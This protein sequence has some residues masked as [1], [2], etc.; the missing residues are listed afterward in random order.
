M[1]FFG[2]SAAPQRRASNQPS[3]EFLRRHECAACPLNREPGLRHPKMAATGATR[4]KAY[5]LAEAPGEVEDRRGKQMVGPAGSILRHHLPA[6]WLDWIR[7]N[8]SIRCRPPDNRDPAKA[9]LACCAP[10]VE[11]DLEASGARAVVG[12]GNVALGWAGVAESGITLWSGRRAPVMIAGRPYWYFPIIHPSAVQRDK[13]WD[14]LQSR[15]NKYGSEM[16]FQFALHLRR[17]LAAIAAGLPEPEVHDVARAK[18]G[19]RWVTG[20]GGDADVERVTEHLRRAATR[21]AAGF[22]YETTGLRPYA[23]GMKILTAGVSTAKDGTLSFAVDHR[24]ARWN[25]RQRRA[26]DEEWRRF[27][28]EAKCRKIAHNA[29]FEM[30]WSGYFYGTEC[31]RAGKWGDSLAQAYVADPTPGTH[32][33]EFLVLQHFGINIKKEFGASLDMGN[34]DREPLEKVLRYQGP[35]AKYCR[36]LHAAQLSELNRDGMRDLYFEH[37]ERIPTAVL[38]QLKGVPV[39]QATVLRLGKKY[40]PRMLDAERNLHSLTPVKKFERRA[41]KPF[42]PSANEDVGKVLHAIGVHDFQSVDEPEL[43][44]IDHV[45][46]REMLKWRKASK[47]YGTYVMPTSDERTRR[48]LEGQRVGG[49]REMLGQTADVKEISSSLIWPDG[50]GHPQTNVNRTRTSRT[51]SHEWN[52][53]NWPKRGAA[54]AI[55]VRGIVEPVEDDEVV[56]SF[57]FGQI[58]ARNVGMESLD[59]ALLESFWE[60]YD[61]HHDFMEQLA[62]LY[63]RWVKEGAKQLARDKALVKVYRNN[64]KHGFVFASFF[65]SGAKK[66]AAVLGIP[67]R[68]SEQ[69]REIFWDRFGGIRDWHGKLQT[70]YYKHGYVTGHSGYRRHAPVSYNELINSPIQADESKIVLDA[71][72][73]LSKIDHDLL[74]ATMEIHDDLTFIWPKKRVDELADIVLREM[75]WTP[76]EWARIAP[77]VVEMSV[78]KN[79]AT[80]KEPAEGGFV[81]YGKGIF[82]SNKYQGVDMPRKMGAL[83]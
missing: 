71:M 10:S 70:D 56:V 54:D 26:L 28:Y 39:N 58:Q 83:K 67:L 50:M 5:F 44:K 20:A 64:V 77:I 2:L 30:E 33:L 73:R 72:T 24:E 32:S 52:Y 6:R 81:Q 66:N 4:A 41:G 27:L 16:E 13:K 19:C 25:K 14:G 65:G 8:N 48:K 11:R 37:L 61:I 79:W 12:F 76:F 35:D 29:A 23:E 74:Q 42:R 31:V 75:L 80:L 46:A 59:R 40:I 21:K 57:D 55:E 68:V 15:P 3:L 18:E 51:S 17:A 45:F 78:G 63:P 34:L 49:L 1:A 9:E 62:R 47:V 69:L 7:W 82:S 53:Q 22:D 43:A 36:L 38:T 60:D